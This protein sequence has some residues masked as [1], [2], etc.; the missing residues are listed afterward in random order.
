MHYRGHE[1]DSARAIRALGRVVVNTAPGCWHVDHV[2][3]VDQSITVVL[4]T[5]EIDPPESVADDDKALAERFADVLNFVFPNH[6]IQVRMCVSR[7]NA[8]RNI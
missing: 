1:S 8:E 3:C 4:G 7:H 2:L 6:E 5:Y